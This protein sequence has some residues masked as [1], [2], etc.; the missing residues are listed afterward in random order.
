MRLRKCENQTLEQDNRT[1]KKYNK[2][3]IVFANFTCSM[4][5]MSKPP[6]EAKF[7]VKILF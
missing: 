4:K 5:G 2:N 1:L 3:K 7:G 6:I